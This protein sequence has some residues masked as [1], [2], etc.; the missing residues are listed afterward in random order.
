MSTMD[1]DGRLLMPDLPDDRQATTALQYHAQRFRAIF[2]GVSEPIALLK[3]DGNLIEVNL[4]AAKSLGIGAEAAIVGKAYSRNETLRVGNACAFRLR[5]DNLPFWSAACW[6]FASA[7]QQKLQESIALAA[8]GAFIS[9]ETEVMGT[10]N[11]PLLLNFSLT[12]IRDPHGETIL[13][14]AQGRDLRTNERTFPQT[15]GTHQPSPNCRTA[16]A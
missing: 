1:L 10:D 5:N 11:R 2:D 13:I 4:T 16:T 14:L 6:S 3:P 9:Y 8:Q 15:T 7:V 12:P